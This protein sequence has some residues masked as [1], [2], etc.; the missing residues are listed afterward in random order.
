VRACWR[1]STVWCLREGI[2]DRS[3]VRV[4]SAAK[5]LNLILQQNKA[6]TA[7]SSLRNFSVRKNV[8]RR[9][10]LPAHFKIHPCSHLPNN[11]G[12]VTYRKV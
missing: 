3:V 12:L 7:R 11:F 10:R 4:Y 9:F 6:S 2:E 5:I 1:A 8:C